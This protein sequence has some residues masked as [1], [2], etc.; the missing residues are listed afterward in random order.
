ML[1]NVNEIYCSFPLSFQPAEELVAISGQRRGSILVSL[2]TCPAKLI[3]EDHV[4]SERNRKVI[5]FLH[6]I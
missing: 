2:P 3:P 5:A 4:C 1:E 6:W